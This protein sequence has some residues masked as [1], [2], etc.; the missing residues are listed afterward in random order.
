MFTAH[1]RYASSHGKAFPS[2]RPGILELGAG[3]RGW[4]GAVVTEEGCRLF[5]TRSSVVPGWG[6]VLARSQVRLVAW[7]WGWGEG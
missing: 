1:P 6:R 5:K 3:G 2:R 7:G 4:W